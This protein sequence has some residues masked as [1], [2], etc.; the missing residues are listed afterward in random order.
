M[1]Q[2]ARA[3]AKPTLMPNDDDE[4]MRK[5]LRRTDTIIVSLIFANVIAI[6]TL[7]VVLSMD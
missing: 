2:A 4:G 5:R 3:K 6:L 1:S 7:F